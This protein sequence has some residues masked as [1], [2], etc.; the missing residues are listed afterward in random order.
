MAY[1]LTTT[2]Q[3][4]RDLKR[5][6]R[7]GLPMEEFRT[8]IRLLVRDGRLPAEYKPHKL[9]GNRKGEWECHIQSDWLLIWK[10]FDDELRLLMI[11]TGS[12]S[13]LFGK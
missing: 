8:V 4:E 7:R 10:Q 13:D 6:I 9:H 1:R 3:F 5:C 12:H 11:N 2:N